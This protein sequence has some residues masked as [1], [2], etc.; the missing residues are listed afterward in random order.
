MMVI[1][2]VIG[3]WRYNVIVLLNN[4]LNSMLQKLD[5]FWSKIFLLWQGFYIDDIQR[6]SCNLIISI[7]IQK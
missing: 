5:N 4:V 7:K 1:L 6:K 3:L 2:I